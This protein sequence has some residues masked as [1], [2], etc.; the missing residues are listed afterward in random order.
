MQPD[1]L[2]E[3]QLLFLHTQALVLVAYCQAVRHRVAHQ[4]HV[5]FR[6]TRQRPS[7][8]HELPIY[9]P[10]S[11]SRRDGLHLAYPKDLK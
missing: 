8:H 5:S 1:A 7:L 2:K 6:L 9:V 10:S 4:L 11:R 3:D